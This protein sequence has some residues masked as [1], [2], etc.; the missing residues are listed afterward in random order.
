VSGTAIT[1]TMPPNGGVEIHF[2]K[3][4]KAFDDPSKL[5]DAIGALVVSQTKL[6]IHSEKSSPDG[7]AWADWTERYAA[8]RHGKYKAHKPHPGQL[9][10]AQGHSILELSSDLLR[11]I[12]HEVEKDYVLI[13]TNLK[14]AG[15]HNYGYPEGHI[16]ERKFLG[17]SQDNLHQVDQLVTDY[18]GG[19][20]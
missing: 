7:S 13:G 16:P 14:Y 15:S 12:V 10:E 6:R 4:L 17:L 18:F 1:I 9:R 20:L 11:S 2:S 8:H 5:L 3:L 19:M